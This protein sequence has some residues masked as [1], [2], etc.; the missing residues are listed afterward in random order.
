MNKY[1]LFITCKYLTTTLEYDTIE[2]LRSAIE[3]AMNNLVLSFAE[4]EVMQNKPLPVILSNV[5]NKVKSL[6]DKH[7]TTQ[8]AE[9]STTVELC[10]N[11]WMSVSFKV[12]NHRHFTDL[13]VYELEGHVSEVSHT[14]FRIVDGKV[15]PTSGYDIDVGDKIALI[16]E[17]TEKELKRAIPTDGY[18]L[19]KLKRDHGKLPIT[20]RGPDDQITLR[21]DVFI[22]DIIQYLTLDGVNT[23]HE[24][25]GLYFSN[26]KNAL[27]VATFSISR[28]GEGEL[29]LMAG[30][31]VLVYNHLLRDLMEIDSL[32]DSAFSECL[33]QPHIQQ[34][35]KQMCKMWQF[36][37]AS[38]H[39]S[40]DIKL[41]LK[42]EYI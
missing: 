7:Q 30:Q 40:K 31:S 28:K 15:I 17:F 27:P 14:N 24:A 35:I 18:P 39:I 29:L 12:P 22:G 2:E 37:F 10:D 25:A 16:D 42:L 20:Y 6:I 23:L 34:N 32:T 21:N 5:G 19:E 36:G 1:Q 26:Y 38:A 13:N 8:Y 33:N 3:P 9:L 41:E 4:C 11:V